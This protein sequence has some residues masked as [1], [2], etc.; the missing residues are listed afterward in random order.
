[1]LFEICIDSVEGALAAQAAGA[2]RVELCD[3]LVEGN[4]SL[5]ESGNHVQTVPF[6]VTGSGTQQSYNTLTALTP[7]D[8]V[9]LNYTG[10]SSPPRTLSCRAPGPHLSERSSR[11]KRP[12]A[13]RRSRLDGAGQDPSHECPLQQ[14][15]DCQRQEHG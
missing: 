13:A 12:S 3:N 5:V 7:G 11:Q 14:Q 4:Y 8:I 6:S 2:Q 15:E 1:M 10:P 9:A